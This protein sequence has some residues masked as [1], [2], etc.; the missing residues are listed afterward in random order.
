MPNETLFLLHISLRSVRSLPTYKPLL[1]HTSQ[2]MRRSTCH[3]TPEHCFT[4]HVSKATVSTQ[5]L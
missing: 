5:S 1:S 2:V 3:F 4:K